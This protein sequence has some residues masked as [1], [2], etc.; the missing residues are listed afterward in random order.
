MSPLPPAL[1]PMLGIAEAAAGAG[2]AGMGRAQSQYVNTDSKPSPH[3]PVT[4]GALAC[5]SAP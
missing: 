3:C 2:A 5:Y 1:A 4:L